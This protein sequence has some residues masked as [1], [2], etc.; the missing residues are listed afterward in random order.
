MPKAKQAPKKESKDEAKA[1][2]IREMNEA[3][4]KRLRT[5]FGLDQEE[6]K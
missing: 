4:N 6:K 5:A 3:M 2:I 1:R